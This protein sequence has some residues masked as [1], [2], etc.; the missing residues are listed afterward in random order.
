MRDEN[1]RSDFLRRANKIRVIADG[2]FDHNER[3]DLLQFVDECEKMAQRALA[4]NDE[5]PPVAPGSK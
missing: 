3:K 4:A 1:E 5:Y 2:L